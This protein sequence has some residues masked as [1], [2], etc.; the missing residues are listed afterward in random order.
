MMADRADTPELVI[1][2]LCEAVGKQSEAIAA[3]ADQIV[4]LAQTN[5]NLV[6][7]LADTASTA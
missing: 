4:S 2:S 3:Q 5:A 6:R 7:K 1:V